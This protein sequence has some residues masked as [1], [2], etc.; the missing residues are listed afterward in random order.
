M[1]FWTVQYLILSEWVF[2]AFISNSV[3]LCLNHSAV[4][5]CTF[6]TCKHF[7]LMKNGLHICSWS[8]IV[9]F[10]PLTSGSLRTHFKCHPAYVLSLLLSVCPP[11]VHLLCVRYSRSCTTELFRLHSDA[12]RLLEFLC[13]RGAARVRERVRLWPFWVLSTWR[14]FPF[15][16][17][18]NLQL[19]CPFCFDGHPGKA[20]HP[21]MSKVPLNHISLSPKM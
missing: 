9:L 11:A 16:R 2:S 17:N 21:H 14:P 15:L 5:K 3:H 13:A 10:T 6:V 12:T 4:H 20:G 1:H 7:I 8:L 18:K 19:T